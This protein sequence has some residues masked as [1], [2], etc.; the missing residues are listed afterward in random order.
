MA[1]HAIRRVLIF[2]TGWRTMGPLSSPCLLAV[3]LCGYVE[4][5]FSSEG[6]RWSSVGGTKQICNAQLLYLYTYTYTRC[7]S[8]ATVGMRAQATKTTWGLCCLEVGYS[9]LETPIPLLLYPAL[10]GLALWPTAFTRRWVGVTIEFWFGGEG[11]VRVCVCVG[12][13]LIGLS[14]KELEFALLIGGKWVRCGRRSEMRW[15]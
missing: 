2:Y 10:D 8:G 7:Q 6:R 12:R 11:C 3:V 15:F 14:L 13:G 9:P 5:A 4:V 1:E